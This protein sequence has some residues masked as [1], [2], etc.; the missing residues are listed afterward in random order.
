MNTAIKTKSLND[1]FSRRDYRAVLRLFGAEK[2]LYVVVFGVLLFAIIFGIA[3]ITLTSFSEAQA[4]ML[5]S[6]LVAAQQARVPEAELA[7]H[8][9]VARAEHIGLLLGA[10]LDG[11]APLRLLEEHTQQDVG[12]RAFRIDYATATLELDVHAPSVEIIAKQ[13]AAFENDT[14]I[15]QVDTAQLTRVEDPQRFETTM[16]IVF[17]AH[18]LR[19]FP[20]LEENI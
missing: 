4:K 2:R 10:H 18:V 5:Q 7:L 3:A 13:V 19:A 16:Q 8:D 6:E 14:R 15:R 9:E 1:A 17:D 11:A 12:I 20:E